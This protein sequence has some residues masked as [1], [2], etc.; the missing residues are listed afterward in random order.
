[1]NT[2]TS[3][4]IHYLDFSNLNFLFSHALFNKQAAE[5]RM[6]CEEDEETEDEGDQGHDSVPNAGDTF[7]VSCNESKKSYIQYHIWDAK[8]MQI[9]M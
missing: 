8:N 4:F 5:K 2:L 7:Q 1:M 3:N 6:Q 9:L